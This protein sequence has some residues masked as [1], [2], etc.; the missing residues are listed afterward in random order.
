MLS[1]IIIKKKLL[2]HRY[3]L[4][5]PSGCGKTTILRAICSRIKMEDG[6]VR[7]LGHSPGSY[8]SGIPGKIIGYMPQVLVYFKI[9]NNFLFFLTLLFLQ[10]IALYNEFTIDETLTYFGYLHNMHSV[11]LARRKEFLFSFLDLGEARKRLV[12]VLR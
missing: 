8:D 5:G 10:E 9:I 2:R 1:K 11:H 4:L 6:E 7:C 3:G 12:K